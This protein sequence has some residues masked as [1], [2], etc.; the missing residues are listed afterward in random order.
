MRADHV[1]V[2]I[3]SSEI[4]VNA[5]WMWEGAV[6]DVVPWRIEKVQSTRC[7]IL[8]IPRMK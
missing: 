2:G 3:P 5:R 8:S 6:A 4:V 1:A 7:C